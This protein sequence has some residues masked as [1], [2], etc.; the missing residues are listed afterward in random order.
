MSTGSLKCR[1]LG[2]LGYCGGGEERGGGGG[3]RGERRG[4][5]EPVLLLLLLLIFFL[6]KLIMIITIPK[7]IQGLRGSIQDTHQ[8]LHKIHFRFEW[9]TFGEVERNDTWNEGF[10]HDV[11]TAHSSLTMGI[12]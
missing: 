7:T 5:E 9:R 11:S 8:H 10:F 2:S 3:E 12:Q 6:A 4:E 1:T